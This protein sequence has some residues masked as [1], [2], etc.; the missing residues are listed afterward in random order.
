MGKR[1]EKWTEENDQF[2]YD[3]VME[4]VGNGDSKTSAFIKAGELLG[5]T[6]SACRYRW[7]TH[8]N[9]PNVLSTDTEMLLL[10]APQTDTKQM[11]TNILSIDSIIQYLRTLKDDSSM[12]ELLGEKDALLE[13]QVKLKRYSLQLLQKY[14]EKKSIYQKMVS[15]YEEVLAI[16][17]EAENLI[18]ENRGIIH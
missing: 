11:N 12:E 9:Q 2:L 3:T 5:R 1:R 18:H 4:Y 6:P 13:Q 16:F 17:E 7:H 8:L 10:P 15:Q 14:D